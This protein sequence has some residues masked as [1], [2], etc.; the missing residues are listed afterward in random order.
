MRHPI[1]EQSYQQQRPLAADGLSHSARHL[2]IQHYA[3]LHPVLLLS[4][5]TVAVLLLLLVIQSLLLTMRQP[6]VVVRA[7]DDALAFAATGLHVPEEDERGSYRW[8]TGDSSIRLPAIGQGRSQLFRLH[9]GPTLAEH[10]VSVLRVGFDDEPAATVALDVRPRQ[11]VFLVPPRALHDTS[12]TVHL[13]SDT[14]TVPPDTRPLGVRVEQASLAVPGAPPVLVSPA[15]AAAQALILVFC[16]AMLGRLAVPLRFATLVLAAVAV[17]LVL[18]WMMQP[19]LLYPY[20]ARWMVALGVLAGLTYL[21]LPL[22]ER[23]L[24]WLASPAMVR[25]LWGIALLACAIRLM[26]SLYPLFAAFD[27]DL[28]VGRFVR[29]AS[30]DLVV[31]SRS[32]E[33]RNGITVYPP[34]GYIVLLPAVLVGLAPPVLIQGSLALLD[35]FGALTTGLLARSFGNSNRTAIFSALLYAAIPIHLTALWFGLTAQIFGQA[36]MAPLAIAILVALQPGQQTGRWQAWGI[37]ALLFTMSLLTHIGVAVIAVAWLGLFWLL[38]GWRRTLSVRLWWRMA[39]VLA[40]CFFISLVG[41][42]GYVIELK[43]AEMQYVADK[44]QTSGYVP[45]YSLIVRAFLISFHEAGLLLLLPGV[46]LLVL[47]H[48]SLPRGAGELIAAWLGVVLLFLGIEVVSALQ[49]RYL[50][51]L[52]PLACVLVGGVLAALSWR[53]RAGWGS[54]WALVVGLL[55]IGSLS[56]HTGAIEGVM[57]SMSPLLR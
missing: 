2:R 8:T 29:T 37:A 20:A 6:S 23:Y 47:Q 25:V 35:G 48:R 39:W 36:L 53:G 49:V 16:A 1:S 17:A 10:P 5:V 26:G 4:A 43:L 15:Q 30:G 31:T 54:A 3:L 21:L 13:R 40:G 14:G 12:L 28:N 46:L 34:G 11:Y 24:A 19:L 55:L 50:Y 22:A 56:W 51:F 7:A 33:F 52:T 44:V 9:L 45:A 32:I 38:L 41:I 27:L 42:Y 57:M 18:F